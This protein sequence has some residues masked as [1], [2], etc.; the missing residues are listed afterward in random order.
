MNVLREIPL[1]IQ[2]PSNPVHTSGYRRFVLCSTLGHVGGGNSCGGYTL[3]G[4]ATT[5]A[6]LQGSGLP[7]A[8]VEGIM[9]KAA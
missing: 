7:K 2:L 5:H 9:L 4:F 3:M 8:K 6:G 1:P